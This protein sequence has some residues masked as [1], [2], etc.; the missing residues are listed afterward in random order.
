MKLDARNINKPIYIKILH[1][2]NCI[3]YYGSWSKLMTKDI[4]CHFT[5]KY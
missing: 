4:L 3:T 1:V 2:D 5:L